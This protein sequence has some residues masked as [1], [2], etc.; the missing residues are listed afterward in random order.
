MCN[1]ELVDLCNNN[2]PGYTSS[3]H[4]SGIGYTSN[5]SYTGNGGYSK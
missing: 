1:A 3:R 4:S 5:I 2:K